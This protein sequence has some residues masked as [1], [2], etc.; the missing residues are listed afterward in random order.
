M[1]LSSASTQS[2][3]YF[4][5]YNGRK[6]LKSEQVLCRTLQSL[7]TTFTGQEKTLEIKSDLNNSESEKRNQR[8]TEK[9]EPVF[10]TKYGTN[11]TCQKGHIAKFSA[12]GPEPNNEK[13]NSKIKYFKCK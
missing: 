3:S 5:E 2:Q 9:I 13:Y 8:S 4:C 7:E 11:F 12:H 1:N 6:G 10:F